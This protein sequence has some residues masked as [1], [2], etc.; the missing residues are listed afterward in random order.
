[1]ESPTPPLQQMG[2]TEE[3]K[4]DGVRQKKRGR[5][6]E[7]VINKQPSVSAGL[8]SCFCVFLLVPEGAGA[9]RAGA[10]RGFTPGENKTKKVEVRIASGRDGCQASRFCVI[11]C[12]Q[13]WLTNSR[14]GPEKRK[15][16]P[17]KTVHVDT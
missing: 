10:G 2:S 6:K 14:A 15:E 11:I 5:Q 16:K 7:T 13:V 9:H 4:C 8:W 3:K 17:N 1:M 12:A